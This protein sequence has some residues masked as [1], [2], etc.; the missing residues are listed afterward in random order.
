MFG[1]AIRVKMLANLGVDWRMGLVSVL[2][3]RGMGVNT[4]VA[5]GFMTF[6]VPSP[7]TL[8][9]SYR[10]D[11]L[12]TLGAVVVALTGGLLVADQIGALL[13]PQRGTFWLDDLL[14]SPI[15]CLLGRIRGC[16]Y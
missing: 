6:L 10:V 15:S 16:L 9:D 14:R 3:D 11:A 7:L 13:V 5:L 12:L 8:A 2:I 4:I 1:E